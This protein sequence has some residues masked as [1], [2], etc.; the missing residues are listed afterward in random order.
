[1]DGARRRGDAVL[2]GRASRRSRPMSSRGRYQRPAIC[3]TYPNANRVGAPDTA[4]QQ[5]LRCATPQLPRDADDPRGALAGSTRSRCSRRLRRRCRALRFPL[6]GLRREVRS[7]QRAVHL[8]RAQSDTDAPGQ[9]R[10]VRPHEQLGLNPRLCG[11][12]TPQASAA[13]PRSE[14]GERFDGAVPIARQLRR[15]GSGASAAQR[16]PGPHTRLPS[17]SSGVRG[18]PVP[19]A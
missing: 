7:R 16:C 15:S 8:P 9:F 10:A 18:A 11:A 5:R 4:P 13:S 12:A 17:S 1:M 6:A 14:A 2:D 19:A 3:A